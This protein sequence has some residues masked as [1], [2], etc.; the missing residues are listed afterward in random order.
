MNLLPLFLFPQILSIRFDN[1][2]YYS[3]SCKNDQTSNSYSWKKLNFTLVRFSNFS[4]P[5]SSYKLDHIIAVILDRTTSDQVKR[6]FGSPCIKKCVNVVAL[7]VGQIIGD[8]KLLQK[9][10]MI[11]PS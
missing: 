7:E 8:E 11:H 3:V 10:C 5:S 4:L 1:S 6:Q 2:M 9:L